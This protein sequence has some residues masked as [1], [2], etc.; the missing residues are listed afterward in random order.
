MADTP[1]S[2]DEIRS[3]CADLGRRAKSASRTLAVASGAVKNRWLL[4]AAAALDAATGSVIA[5]NERDLARA[6]E[7]GLTDAQI[8]RLRLTPTRIAAVAAGLRE[9]AALPDPVGR[10]IDGSTRPNG[11]EIRKV[12]VPIGV[13]FF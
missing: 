3:L 13:L 9:V 1:V 2:S 4:D 11:L 5:A 12:G 6:P 7:L 10:V 8:D